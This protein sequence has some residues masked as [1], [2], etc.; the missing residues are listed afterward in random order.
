MKQIW[1]ILM[2]SKN[3]IY[4]C[5]VCGAEQSDPPWGDNGKDAT[6]NIC[7]CCGVEFG[8]EDAT[9]TG[10]KRYREKWLTSG[11]KWNSEKSKP[12]NWLLDEQ[13]KNVPKDYL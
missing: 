7:D 3:E 13:L 8:Y 11:A 6:F 2:H 12:E 5:R 10:I 4:V 1:T 9:L